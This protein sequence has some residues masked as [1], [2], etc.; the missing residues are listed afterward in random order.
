[1]KLKH[2]DNWTMKRREVAERYQ[3]LFEARGSKHLTMPIE[4]TG[5]FHV[6]NQYVIRVPAVI[7]DPLREYLTARQIGTEIYYPI[8]LHLQPCF[9]ALA[10]KPGDFP[11]SESAAK[12]TI[13]LPMYPELTEEQQRFVVGSIC[14]FLELHAAGHLAA[15][16]AA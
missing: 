11:Q 1:V 9:A 10:H 12:E 8:P 16:K 13:A 7:R 14:Q 3:R 6:Y 5:Y 4:R 15:D 2:L